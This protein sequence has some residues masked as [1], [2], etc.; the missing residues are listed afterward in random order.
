MTK[1]ITRLGIVS[2]LILSFAAACSTPQAALQTSVATA[3][4][5]AAAT[6]PPVATNQPVETSSPSATNP[7]TTEATGA[8]ASSSDAIK[9][10]VLPDKSTASYRVREQ[11]ANANLPNDAV[12]TT[13]AISGTL[14]IQSDGTIDAANSKFVVDL[15]TLQTDR[16]QRDNFVRRNIL[17]TDQFPQAV[18]VPTQASG[19]ATPL[20]QSGDV[21]F[22]LTGNLTIRDTTKPVTWDVSGQIQGGAFSGKATTSFKFEDFNLNQPRVPVVLSVVDNIT[23]ELDFTMQQ[24]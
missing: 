8:P 16:S 10:V 13:N 20:P 4:S 3:A 15:A 9:F 22:Q 6:N 21:S 24:Q 17:G 5:Q 2:I 23:L 7:A 1:H 14:T 12:G 11:L 19:L 18:F